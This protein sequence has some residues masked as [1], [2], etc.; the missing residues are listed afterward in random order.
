MKAVRLARFVAPV[1]LLALMAARAPDADDALDTRIPTVR[2]DATPLS[3]AIDFIRD[4]VKANIQVDWKTLEA[5]GI[6]RSTP[7]TFHLRSITAR[8][9]LDTILREAGAG[10]KLAYD[11]DEN[12]VEITTQEES[13]KKLV[14]EVYDV[15]DLQFQPLDAGQAPNIQFQLDAVTRGGGGGGNGGSLFPGGTNNAANNERTPEQQGAELADI[16]QTLIRPEIW[17]PQGGPASIRYFNGTLIVSAP[18][19]VHELIGP[20]VRP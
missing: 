2:F 17:L 15:R 10:A 16:I 11:V 14:T 12:T 7:V 4:A 13:D 9:A 1:A 20:A 3:D 18:R 6:D 5:A 8:K 19:S